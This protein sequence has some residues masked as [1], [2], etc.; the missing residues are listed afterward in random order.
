MHKNSENE[1]ETCQYWYA[2]TKGISHFDNNSDKKEFV[3]DWINLMIYWNFT[4]WK[5]ASNKL[6][7]YDVYGCEYTPIPVPHFSG[8]FWWAN[9]QYIKT[10][11]KMIGP[12]YCD[13]EF[14][15]LKKEKNMICNIYSSG[16]DGGDHYY[17]KSNFFN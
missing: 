17:Y 16:L 15:L 2:H 9:A 1:N 7:K 13:P 4:K 3:I 10:I 5:I 8:N 14:W 6:F 12:D 11:S